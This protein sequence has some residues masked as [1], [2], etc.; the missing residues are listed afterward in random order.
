MKHV[1]LG[2]VGYGILLG[3]F[4][5]PSAAAA[6]DSHLLIVAGLGGDPEYRERFHRWAIAL[7]DAARDGSG[8]APANV[9]YLGERPDL[10]PDRVRDRSTREN[11]V[12]AFDELAQR[13]GSG[14]K[15][16]VVLIGHGSFTRGESR[17]N[18][19]GPD[20]T[21][22]DFARQL[23]RFPSQQVLFANTASASGEFLEALS[24]P[25]RT[26]V[27][28]TR[29]GGERNETIFGGFFVEALTAD[30]AD[31]DKDDRV[32][33]LEAFSYARRQVERAYEQDG[34]LLT[35]HAQLDDNGDGQGSSEPDPAAADGAVARV[36]FLAPEER[37]DPVAETVAVE[38]PELRELLDERHALEAR[39]DRLRASKSEMAPVTYDAQL[40]ALL[41]ELALKSRAIRQRSD[42]EAVR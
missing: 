30:T 33:I 23:D 25:R 17:F 40:E 26:V 18:L 39:V 34:R 22:D 6:Q 42:A 13:V 20:M 28:A 37:R 36:L 9:V 31:T 41:V 32:S 5:V 10:D 15:V 21:A 12:R 35:E 8:V 24:G 29:T 3:L 1:R 4:T 14:D 27:T 7:A 38:D 19:P 11:V 2:W 16:F